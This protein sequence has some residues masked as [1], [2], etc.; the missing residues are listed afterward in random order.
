[1]EKN[2][3]VF[4]MDYFAG[5]GNIAHVYQIGITEFSF[6]ADLYDDNGNKIC[7]MDFNN[8]N[9]W[10]FQL[11]NFENKINFSWLFDVCTEYMNYYNLNFAKNDDKMKT[12]NIQIDGPFVIV[13]FDD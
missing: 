11:S 10:H 9:M 8:D 6:G 13:N 2:E 7:Y 1:M 3:I 4:L 5:D 12:Y